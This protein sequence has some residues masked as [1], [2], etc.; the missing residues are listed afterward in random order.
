M[1]LGVNWWF[2]LILL[3]TVA[4]S[5]AVVWGTALPVGR[6]RVRFPM[7][8]LEF[9]IDIILPAPGSDSASNRNEYQEYFLWVGRG[10]GGRCVG[11]MTLLSSHADC[12]EIL[13]AWISWNPVDS[14]NASLNNQR[15]FYLR[16]ST[17]DLS[18]L[19]DSESGA[20]GQVCLSWS[21]YESYDKTEGRIRNHLH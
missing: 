7:V 16:N 18:L 14:V 4:R 17:F 9:F 19:T 13:G 15:I 12:L 2:L 11:L 5:G 8:S 3:N 21:S 6:S 1:S 20:T 10:K